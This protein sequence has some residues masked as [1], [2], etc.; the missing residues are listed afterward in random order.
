MDLTIRPYKTLTH[1]HNVHTHARTHTHTHQSG[2][3]P[4]EG[5]SQCLLSLEFSSNPRLGESE[6]LLGILKCPGSP[7]L[8]FLL[9]SHLRLHTSSSSFG[10]SHSVSSP[11]RAPSLSGPLFWFFQAKHPPR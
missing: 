2:K 1:K 6:A 11:T 4:K 9:H 5:K 10:V 7:P 8:L 3:C